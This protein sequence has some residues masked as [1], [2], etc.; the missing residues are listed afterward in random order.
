MLFPKAILYFR[1]LLCQQL[2]STHLVQ[3]HCAAAHDN[4]YGWKSW[5]TRR[6]P[7]SISISLSRLHA[8][9][10]IAEIHNSEVWC[11]IHFVCIFHKLLLIF[12]N[13]L[14]SENPQEWVSGGLVSMLGQT[15]GGYVFNQVTRHQL[16]WEIS[17]LWNSGRASPK[18]PG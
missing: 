1:V 7:I 11:S 6:W 14:E 2:R 13:F 17:L 3:V 18:S 4:R 12:C 9:H 16:H 5:R 8:L 15:L 10:S